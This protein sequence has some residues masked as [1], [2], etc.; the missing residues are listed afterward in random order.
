VRILTEQRDA[1][2]ALT[3]EATRAEQQARDSHASQSDVNDL[4]RQR[5]GLQQSLV[6]TTRDLTE[7]T[8][9]QTEWMEPWKDS[10]QQVGENVLQGVSTALWDALEG[11][12]AFDAAIHD[13]LKTVAKSTAQQ[14]IFE[15]L[16]ATA[17]GFGHLSK[18]NVFSATKAFKSAGLWAA[19]G[20]VAG[21]I[22]GALSASSSPASSGGDSSARSASTDRPAR[23]DRDRNG[24]GPLVINVAVSG[25]A[26]TDAGVHQAVA[27]ALRGATSSGYLTSTDLR[28]LYG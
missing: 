16:K 27:S 19:T 25:A 28:G 18:G 5:I 14:A 11:T 7:A 1:L 17:E 4:M 9:E 20:V 10:M 13:M 24:G 21:G 8:R 22:A 12:K 6:E 2:R 3:D 23:A 26:F 15:T